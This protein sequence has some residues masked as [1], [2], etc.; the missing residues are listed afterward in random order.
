MNQ[1]L[2]VTYK[3]NPNTVEHQWFPVEYFSGSDVTIYIGDI[4]I[5]EIS[6]LSFTLTEKVLPIFG[7]ASKTF[8]HASRGC[9][10]VEGV[11]QIPFVEAGYLE[12]I[13]SRVGANTTETENAKPKLA[14]VKS[15]QTVP[16]WCADFKMDIEGALVRD[17]RSKGITG[18]TVEETIKG[19]VLDTPNKTLSTAGSQNGLSFVGGAGVGG[20]DYTKK[21][22]FNDRVEDYEAEVWGRDFSKDR[23]RKYQHFFYE[24]RKREDGTN[25]QEILKKTGFDIYITYGPQ[26]EAEKY[27]TLQDS[28]AK[29]LQTYS[30]NTTVKAIRG[31]QL[32]STGQ[33]ISANGNPLYEEYSFIAKDLD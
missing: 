15:G 8:D 23:D 25:T 2:G 19:I 20:L 10:M 9:R 21:T 32:I 4:F 6:A 28:K 33:T 18:I 7:Y 14:Y 11:I 17:A 27:N 5:S 26:A 16:K 29:A 13:L 1:I 3:N 22:A 12:S 30:F 24:D 31:I